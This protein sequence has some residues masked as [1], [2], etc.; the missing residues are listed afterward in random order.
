MD[1]NDWKLSFKMAKDDG[2]LS[3]QMA[4]D[5]G[6]LSFPMTKDDRK[7]FSL[8]LTWGRRFVT[9]AEAIKQKGRIKFK[10]S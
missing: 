1:Q 8:Y 7:L 4:K 6:K 5:D 10:K 3:F 9:E 2:K